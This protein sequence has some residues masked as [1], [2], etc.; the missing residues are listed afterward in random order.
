M[1]GQLLSAGLTF[2]SY[3]E[4]LPAVGSRVVKSGNYFRKHDPA[5]SFADVPPQDNVPFSQFPQTP[6][7]FRHLPLRVTASGI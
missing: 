5:A 2:K 6:K 1:S 7:G 4:G 3:A